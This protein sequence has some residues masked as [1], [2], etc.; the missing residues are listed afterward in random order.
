[1]PYGEMLIYRKVIAVMMHSDAIESETFIALRLPRC[2]IP[3]DIR[4]RIEEIGIEIHF[5]MLAL[6]YAKDCL[7]CRLWRMVVSDSTS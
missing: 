3:T 1:M 6:S 2:T 5:F 4:S 7:T